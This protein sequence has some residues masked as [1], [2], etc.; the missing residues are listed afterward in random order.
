MR[1]TQGLSTHQGTVFVQCLTREIG[2]SLVYRETIGS[3]RARASS[4][5]YLYYVPAC[6]LL[7][8]AVTLFCQE[9]LLA[10]SEQSD[11]RM[12]PKG[13]TPNVSVP[14]RQSTEI[15]VSFEL[16]KLKNI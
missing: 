5:D 16:Q 1:R 2:R 13:E 12:A 8:R 14:D 3:H 4:T 10:D 9:K 7:C 15:E 6:F 11:L